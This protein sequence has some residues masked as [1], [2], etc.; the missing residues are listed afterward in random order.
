VQQVVAHVAGIDR[1]LHPQPIEDEQQRAIE[2]Q[3]RA[4]S[5]HVQAHHPQRV[6]RD[7]QSRHLSLR[8]RV[9]K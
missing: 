1:R 8:K 9:G 3:A 2:Q 6:Y 5:D 7:M 4:K